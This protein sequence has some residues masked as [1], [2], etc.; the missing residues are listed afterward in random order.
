MVAMKPLQVFINGLEVSVDTPDE[1]LAIENWLREYRIWLSQGPS[2]PK[3][4]YNRREVQAKNQQLKPLGKRFCSRC[5]RAKPVEE[6]ASHGK[7][8]RCYSCMQ[9]IRKEARERRIRRESPPSDH[10]P[11]ASVPADAP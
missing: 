10:A 9:T 7:L 6:F 2:V 8:S 4:T 3:T 5:K 11:S 1:L